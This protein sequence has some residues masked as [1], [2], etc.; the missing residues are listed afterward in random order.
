MGKKDEEKKRAK[1]Y[2]LKGALQ[3]EIA[4]K[5]N[6]QPKTISKWVKEGGWKALRNTKVNSHKSQIE[7]TRELISLLT[8]ERIKTQ[9]TLI[10]LREDLKQYEGKTDELSLQLVSDLRIKMTELLTHSK[11]LSDEISKNNK[12]LE[13]LD[14]ENEVSFSVYLHVMDRVFKALKKDNEKL[15]LQTI[16]FQED[17]INEVSQHYS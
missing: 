7:Q 13:N 9:S 8:E 5:L 3:K 16:D 10:K 14:K 17:H 6:V 15:Y 11:G 12:V 1:E 2:F 4:I